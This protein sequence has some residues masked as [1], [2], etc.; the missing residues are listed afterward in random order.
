M[1]GLRKKSDEQ[2]QSR[3]YGER[4]GCINDQI[5]ISV[6]EHSGETQPIPL[7][8]LSARNKIP[9]ET[10]PRPIQS[11]ARINLPIMKVYS[12]KNKSND[13]E[14][15]L[16][17]LTR[18]I[19]IANFSA[20]QICG[21]FLSSTTKTGLTIRRKDAKVNWYALMIQTDWLW[22]KSNFRTREGIAENNAELVRVYRNCVMQ[23]MKRRVYLRAFEG[24]GRSTTTSTSQTEVSGDLLSSDDESIE[25]F[26]MFRAVVE[27][28]M[29]QNKR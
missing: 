23:K 28:T 24:A 11:I 17:K 4:R 3:W 6:C 12:S 16:G 19:D 10:N 13:R 9:S 20:L 26:C 5:S 18:I 21:K 29:F 14:D 22:A 1:L 7:R 15:S 27:L 25:K 8:A 2:C